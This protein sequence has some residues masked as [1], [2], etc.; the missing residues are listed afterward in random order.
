M[1]LY[2]GIINLNLYELV[3]EDVFYLWGYFFIVVKEIFRVDKFF[4]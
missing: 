2:D 4:F 1:R 3:C